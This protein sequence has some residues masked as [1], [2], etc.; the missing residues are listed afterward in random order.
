MKAI[1]TEARTETFSAALP[2][3]SIPTEQSSQSPAEKVS[4]PSVPIQALRTCAK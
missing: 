3:T 2:P 4:V 1:E